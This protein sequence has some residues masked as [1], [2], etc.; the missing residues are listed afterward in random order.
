MKK[1]FL[2][3]PFF[4]QTR[5]I[6]LY[7]RQNGWWISHYICPDIV[8]YAWKCG[9][10]NMHATIWGWLIQ[11]L[12][13]GHIRDGLHL[14]LPHYI[15]VSVSFKSA[16]GGQCQRQLLSLFVLSQ[17]CLNTFF[18]FLFVLVS[19][20][21]FVF[22]LNRRLIRGYPITTV[23]VFGLRTIKSNRCLTWLSDHHSLFLCP[24][25]NKIW[26]MFNEMRLSDH[27]GPSLSLLVLLTKM[28]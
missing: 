7:P 16:C 19:A 26:T 28:F 24:A 3:T 15:L 5:H 12:Y 9:K 11:V 22:V 8:V 4:R 27:H 18:Y 2:G 14:G 23:P 1:L 10:P 20:L 25:H 6:P 13:S 21:V 17:W